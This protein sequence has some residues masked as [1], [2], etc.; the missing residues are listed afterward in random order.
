MTP[1]ALQLGVDTFERIIRKGHVIE[2][3]DLEGRCDVTH[4]ALSLGRSEPKLSG[5]NVAVAAGAFPWSAP[6]RSASATHP[7][8]LRGS[9]TAIAGGF[10]VGAGQ[11]PGAMIDP[12]R[13]PPRRGMAVG[14]PAI[15]HFGGELIAVRVPVAVYA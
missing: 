8:A 11:R 2:R 1:E 12:G 10:S 3:V 9:M 5:M 4:F 6:V 15:G 13:V 7:V 14:T